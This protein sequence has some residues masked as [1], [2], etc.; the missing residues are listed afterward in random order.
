M[1]ILSASNSISFKCCADSYF[2]GDMRN[3]LMC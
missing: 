1:N 3:K 2:V